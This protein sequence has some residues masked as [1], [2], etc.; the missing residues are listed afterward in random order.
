MADAGAIGTCQT[1]SGLSGAGYNFF[2]NAG[3][4][5]TGLNDTKAQSLSDQSTQYAVAKVSLGHVVLSY[6]ESTHTYRVVGT[7]QENGMPVENVVV[8]VFNRANGA[9]L[10]EGVSNSSGEFSLNILGFNG[11]V[12]V[13]GYDVSGGVSY[14]AVVFDK[15]IPII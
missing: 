11:E 1:A 7:T 6:I 2:D 12:T 13:V 15:V 8:R 5:L 10:A 3:Y 9:M 14:N 4:P